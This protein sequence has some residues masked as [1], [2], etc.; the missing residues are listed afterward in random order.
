MAG[1]E[2]N[3]VPGRTPVFTFCRTILSRNATGMRVLNFAGAMVVLDFST[4]TEARDD[5]DTM[6]SVMPGLIVRGVV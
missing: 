5:S 2:L 6:E 4:V 3:P 1:L